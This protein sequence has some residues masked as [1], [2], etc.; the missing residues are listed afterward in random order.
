MQLIGPGVFQPGEVELLTSED[1]ESYIS[2]GLSLLR[3]PIRIKTCL[4]KSI[5]LTV[6]GKPVISV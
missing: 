2:Q 3:Y 4:F 5:R 6:I 1:G